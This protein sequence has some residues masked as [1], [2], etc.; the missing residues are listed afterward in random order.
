M[1]KQIE[2]LILAVYASIILGFS[3]FSVV[4]GLLWLVP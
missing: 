4:T 1:G 2:N 3:A